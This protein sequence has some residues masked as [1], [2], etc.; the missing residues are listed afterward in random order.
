MYNPRPILI[1]GL[2]NPLLGD[3]GIGVVLAQRLAEEFAA[4]ADV[5]CLE[6]GTGGM[7]LLHVLGGR[8]KAV[9]LDCALMGQAPGTW[10]RFTLAEVRTRHTPPG[11]SLHEGDLLAL[12]EL[13]GKLE[14]LPPEVVIIGIEPELLAP[15]LALS[16]LLHSRIEEYLAVVREE[17]Q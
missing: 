15:D 14:T 5:E 10:R 16:P 1:I 8:Q 7:A 4:Q 9:L 17:L 2:G 3:E 13:A 11:F 6:L 12:L